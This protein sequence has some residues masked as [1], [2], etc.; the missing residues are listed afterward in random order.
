MLKE[1]SK[2]KPV[3]TIYHLYKIQAQAKLSQGDRNNLKLMPLGES[4]S[5]WKIVQGTFW[6]DGMFPILI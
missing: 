3:H 1:R 2:H 5:D 6:S 4:R